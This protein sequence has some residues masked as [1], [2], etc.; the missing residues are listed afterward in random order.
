M[1][2]AVILVLG[3]ATALLGSLSYSYLKN[4]RLLDTSATLLTAKEALIGYAITYADKNTGYAFGYLPCPDLDGSGGTPEGAQHGPCG[5]TDANSIGRLPWKSLGLPALRDSDGE[6]LW[7]A[8]SGSYKNN[9]ISATAMNWDNTSKLQV[10]DSSGTEILANEIVA[11]I[12]APHSPSATMTQ[13]RSG[14]S[15]PICGG[16]YNPA[17]YL[18]NDT[19]HNI[20]NGNATPLKF[21]MRHEDRDINDKLIASVND[22]IVYITRQDIWP[23]I[24]SRI[25]RDTK[26]CLDDYAAMPVPT[27]FNIPSW[28]Y[29]WA[30]PITD[31][32]RGGLYSTFFGRIPAVPV[33]TSVPSTPSELLNLQNSLDML[34]NAV[35]ACIN[36]GSSSNG[37][38]LYNAAVAVRAVSGPTDPPPY[39]NAFNVATAAMPS[40]I[41]TAAMPCDYIHNHPGNAMIS[42]IYAAVSAVASAV[43]GTSPTPSS[44]TSMSTSWPA[45]CNILTNKYWTDWA[46]LVFYQVAQPY[47][48]GGSKDCAS[49]SG[50]LSIGG[51]GNPYSGS[52]SYRAAIIVA[53]KAYSAQDRT[54]PGNNPPDGYLSNAVSEVD[55]SATYNSHDNS[56]LTTTFRTYSAKDAAS[57]VV[58]DVVLCLDGKNACQ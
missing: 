35:N 17:A 19:T 44:D 9:P 38:N 13:D 32:N 45:S 22:Q 52:G 34:Q 58:N 3:V 55:P 40:P 29:P 11:V 1:V 4:Q 57:R 14:T 51:S 25:A 6:C 48:P 26:T 41:G 47:A 5:P 39:S 53:G 36:N 56:A 27:N 21:I 28:K 30:A 54:S 43:A 50:C 15:A 31:S 8:I 10:F 16:N 23:A 20:N 37:T 2:M 49:G 18:D 24:Q 42:N 12:I 7:Y 46:N 33:V